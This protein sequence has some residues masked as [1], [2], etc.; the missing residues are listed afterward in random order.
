[1][2]VEHPTPEELVRAAYPTADVFVVSAEERGPGCF[3]SANFA[4][5]TKITVEATC[6]VCGVKHTHLVPSAS[7]LGLGGD[8]TSAWENAAK[9]LGLLK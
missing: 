4:V 2:S 5:R 8:S 3:W 1:M 6:P 7:F 9:H